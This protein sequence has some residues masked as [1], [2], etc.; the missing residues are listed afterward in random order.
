MMATSKRPAKKKPIICLQDEV[1]R[2]M[3]RLEGG[4]SG[5]DMRLAIALLRAWVATE[6]EP[7]SDREWLRM[8]SAIG[9]KMIEES[10]ERSAMGPD[11]LQGWCNPDHVS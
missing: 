1:Y 9:I 6:R 4:R 10:L 2:E 8:T 5:A 11:E 3:F 7:A